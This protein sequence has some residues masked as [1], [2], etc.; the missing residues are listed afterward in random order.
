MKARLNPSW[1]LQLWAAQAKRRLGISLPLLSQKAHDQRPTWDCGAASNGH[2][3]LQPPLW[4]LS[5]TTPPG[6]PKQLPLDSSRIALLTLFSFDFP[7]GVAFR[8]HLTDREAGWERE[9]DTDGHPAGPGWDSGL[10][11]HHAG[12]QAT[13]PVSS[14]KE[15][16]QF[17]KKCRFQAPPLESCAVRGYLENVG[18]KKLWEPVPCWVAPGQEEGRCG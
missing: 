14:L 15:L 1:G 16:I 3:P 11:P 12:S 9:E 6:T 5:I 17:F 7:S 2:P 13:A 4:S 18:F 8:A 10:P